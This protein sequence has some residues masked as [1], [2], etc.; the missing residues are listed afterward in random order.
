MDHS[1]HIE[2]TAFSHKGR[3]RENNEDSITVAGWVSDVEMSAPRRSRHALAQPLL[4]AVADGMGGHAGGEVASRY[5]IKRLAAERLSE[6][7][8]DIAARLAMINAELYETMRAVPSLLGMGTTVAGVLLSARRAIWFNVG[9][10]R[11]YRQRGGWIEQLSIDDVPPG[12][13][14]GIITQTLGGSYAFF[15]I[16][17]HIGEED[18]GEEDL[19]QEDLG[20]E[21]LTHE[22]LGL[23]SRWLVCSDGLTDMLGDA[24]IERA[25]AASDEDALRAMFTAAMQAGG[26]DNISVVLVRMANSQCRA[27]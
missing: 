25:M 20:A 10:S 15:P 8:A 27:D 23:A 11:I 7:T 13:R 17:P 4:F 22:D 12:R 9:D 26:A 1:P 19:G 18:L 24:E 5:A 21:D 14:S 2:V 16:A 6:G 3:V